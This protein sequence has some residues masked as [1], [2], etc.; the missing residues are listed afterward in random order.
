MSETQRKGRK[1][2]MREHPLRVRESKSWQGPSKRQ[3]F[4]N[5]KASK[6]RCACVGGVLRKVKEAGTHEPVC[7]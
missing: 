6:A 1:V 3:K 2:Q 5:W 7:E 4:F